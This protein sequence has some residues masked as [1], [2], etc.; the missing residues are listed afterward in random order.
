MSDPRVLLI[1]YTRADGARGGV[2]T[3]SRDLYRVFPGLECLAAEDLAV[4]LT[5]GRLRELRLLRA[6]GREAIR[7]H[8]ERPFDLIVA[9]G[10]LAMAL[11]EPLPGRPT[12]VVVVMP[13]DYAGYSRQAMTPWHPKTL[14]TKWMGSRW[15]RASVRRADA[16]VS[17]SE[18]VARDVRRYYGCESI[19]LE[20]GVEPAAAGGDLLE[21]RRRLGLDPN[22][23]VV[24]FVGRATREKGYD[25]LLRLAASRPAYQF[26]VVSPTPP[27]SM[28]VGARAF[29]NCEAETLSA[30]YRSCDVLF[31]PSRF[32]GCA[33]V[34]LEAMV[35]GAPVVTS[36]TGVF[37]GLSGPFAG[38][39]IV[40][41]GRPEDWRR[42]VD[43]V[44]R[45]RRTFDPTGYIRARFSFDAFAAG[46]REL[47]TTL[48]P[49]AFAP[50]T[51]LESQAGD[52]DVPG[53][54]VA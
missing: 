23:P 19:V 40:D 33:Y 34:P 27:R 52:E 2:E 3:F 48:V 45:T 49:G 10:S 36:A 1:T 12:P 42:A 53:V 29:V 44:I 30:I 26:V 54:R 43:E 11:P 20:N 15:E 50:S 8:L 21:M 25:R 28:P 37:A 18:G 32:E 4:N 6:L 16:V 51:G 17:V 47:A 38:G 46:Y 9:N 5:T 39:W 13:G 35:A 22:R 31:F 24:A 7:R 14:Y 41:A